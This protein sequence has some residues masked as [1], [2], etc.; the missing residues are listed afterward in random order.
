MTR[1]ELRDLVRQIV[2]DR[3]RDHP[4]ARPANADVSA[5][6]ESVTGDASHALYLSIVNVGDACVIEPAVPC[7]HCGYCKSHGH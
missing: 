6:G 1:D 3:L 4:A 7:N 5:V 2:A